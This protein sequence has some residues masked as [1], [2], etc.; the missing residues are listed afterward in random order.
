MFGLYDLTDRVKETMDDFLEKENEKTERMAA[1]FNPWLLLKRKPKKEVVSEREQVANNNKEKESN[2][3]RLDMDYDEVSTK[4]KAEGARFIRANGNKWRF[5]FLKTKEK[6]Q[7]IHGLLGTYETLILG[8]PDELKEK[9]SKSQL[10][11]VFSHK[12]GHDERVVVTIPSSITQQDVNDLLGYDEKKTLCG[13]NLSYDGDYLVGDLLS[14]PPHTGY[15]GCEDKDWKDWFKTTTPVETGETSL[16]DKICGNDGGADFVVLRCVS[17]NIYGKWNEVA[18]VGILKKEEELGKLEK[19]GVVRMRKQIQKEYEFH[20]T[21]LELSKKV[22]ADISIQKFY[23]NTSGSS[24]T[25]YIIDDPEYKGKKYLV[26]K[27]PHYKGPEIDTIDGRAVV[28]ATNGDK[29]IFDYKML[30]W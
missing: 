20:N 28:I 2:K 15:Y 11:L 1:V 23:G 19:E 10:D 25:D 29:N 9:L 24:K 3:R 30:N 21:A 22:K 7:T 5:G 8:T 16:I 4:L 13:P 17:M 14:F 12:T 27:V 26:E 18:F 6:E